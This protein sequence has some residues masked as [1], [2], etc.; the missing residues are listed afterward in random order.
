MGKR[1]GSTHIR[2]WK[3]DKEDLEG[4]MDE[5]EVE[6]FPE[7]VHLMKEENKSVEEKEFDRLFSL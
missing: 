2:V 5:Y 1:K 7:L 4:L 6:S 3:E